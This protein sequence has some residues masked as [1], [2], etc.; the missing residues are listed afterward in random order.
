MIPTTRGERI[1]SGSPG[2]ADGVVERAWETI[3]GFA[4]LIAVSGSLK[5]SYPARLLRAL[6]SAQPMGFSRAAMPIS[7][8]ERH[9][10]A[11][12]PPDIPKSGYDRRM[13]RG[14]GEDRS[15]RI[16]GELSK[17]HRRR[18]RE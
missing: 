9:G 4:P 16:G 11:A 3:R 17:G 6:P 7:D 18:W 8:A 13:E 12:L 10:V 15:D 5:R 2:D 14:A 1:G